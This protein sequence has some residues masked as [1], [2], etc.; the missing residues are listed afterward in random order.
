MTMTDTCVKQYVDYYRACTSVMFLFYRGSQYMHILEGRF[1]VHRSCY[2]MGRDD[3]DRSC[4]WLYSGRDD[5]GT[6][7][8]V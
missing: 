3:D 5:G 7:S 1:R 6:V 4:T 8:P 2:S